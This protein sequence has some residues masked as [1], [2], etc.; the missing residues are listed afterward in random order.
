MRQ[1]R[2]F[3]ICVLLGLVTV[4]ADAGEVIDR[5]VASVNR[6]VI[7]E[8]ELQLAMAYQCLVNQTPC[9]PED[10]GERKAALDKLIDQSLLEQQ[11]QQAQLATA[12]S[13]DTARLVESLKKQILGP[14]TAE[15]SWRVTLLR[16]GLS[17]ED[18]ARQALR[19]AQVLRFVDSHFRGTFHVEESSVDEYYQNVLAPQLR[20]SG[21]PVPDLPQVA[22]R[23]REILA[24]QEI[25]KDLPAWLQTLREQSEVRIR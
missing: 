18:V 13:G 15:Q 6:R 20:A 19:Q 21:E 12:V 10:A 16:Y 1:L 17:E 9:H 25:N 3:S 4:H 22:D 11:M 14:A 2:R 24:Q 8:S 5:I 23:I 7:L